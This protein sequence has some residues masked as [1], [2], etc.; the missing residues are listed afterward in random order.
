MA[1]KTKC[2][3][4]NIVFKDEHGL[5][6]HKAAKHPIIVKEPVFNG[7]RIRNWAIFIISASIVLSIGWVI[8]S[9]YKGINSCKTAPVTD[10]NIG[11]HTNLALHIHADLNIIIDGK[12]QL[13]PAN[14]GILPGIMRPMHTHASDN[15]IH[16]EGPCKREFRLG[17]FFEI[18]GKEFINSACIFDKCTTDGILSMRVNG[19]SNNE[20]NRYIIK[21]HDSIVIEYNSE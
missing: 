10:I 12:N 6:Q 19:I 7:R 8:A 9:T 14:I 16:I 4:C 17:E 2:E 5:A 20:Y 18:W 3:I 1:E 13:I 15:I 11:G 21:D